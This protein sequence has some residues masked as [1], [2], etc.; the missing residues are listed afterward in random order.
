M[1]GVHDYYAAQSRFTDPGPMAGW[2]AEVGPSL[3]DVRDAAAGLVFHFHAN[4]PIAD[5]GFGPERAGEITLGYAADVLVRLHALNPARPGRERAVTERVVGNCRDV[6][7][8]Y[9]AMA[10]QRGIPARVRVGFA[11]YLAPGPQDHV[12][13]EV[14]D[15]A[16]QR[17]RL[18]EPGSAAGFSDVVDGTA[19]D[20]LDV[21]RDEFLV[22][23]AAWVASDP[24]PWARH[25]S[26]SPP[27]R[28]RRCPAAGNSCAPTSSSPWPR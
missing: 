10:R 25:G 6:A 9:V 27:T 8:L 5:H 23:A 12:V 19:L 22:G 24:E 18:V 2:L 15:A 16:E 21:P 1:P 7:V 14:W 3:A 17:W 20:L 26:C 11:T 13:A 28:T 4:G